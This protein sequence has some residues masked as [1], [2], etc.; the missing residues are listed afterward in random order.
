MNSD[1]KLENITFLFYCV[2]FL[3]MVFY[4]VT[5]IM[6]WTY[7]WNQISI[8]AACLFPLV[9]T[10]CCKFN[11]REFSKKIEKEILI[12]FLIIIIGLLN[13]YYSDDY[14]TTVKAMTLFLV[15]GIGA[16]IVTLLIVNNRRRQ[17]TLLTL[18]WV[19]L[20]L[21]CVHGT[22]EFFFN[23]SPLWFAYRPHLKAIHLGSFNPIPAGSLLILLIMGPLVLY[24][25]VNKWLQIVSIM[26]IIA[27]CIIILAIGK[28]GPVVGII[29][30]ILFVSIF[31][32]KQLWVTIL[33]AAMLLSAYGLG[34]WCG[35]FAPL[36]L[37][38][39]LK[40]SNSIAWRVENYFLAMHILPQRPFC[41]IGLHAPIHPYLTDYSERLNINSSNSHYRNY[42]K[43]LKTF[44]NSF[45]LILVEMGML[46][47]IAYLSLGGVI[48]KKLLNNC[49]KVKS[50]KKNAILFL[51]PL[52]GFLIHSLTFDSLAYPHLNWLFHSFLGLL[53]NL[54]KF[55]IVPRSENRQP[56]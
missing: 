36:Q 6:M 12:A 32:R 41:G 51:A 11:K 25:G 20:I 15:S 30:A 38:S 34:H 46:M 19:C 29:G 44:E 4:S 23:K 39:K 14:S 18:C 47:A 33:V 48:I 8:V 37:I 43:D 3:F 53:A 40:T 16:F 27:A 31:C 28:L 50:Q 45:L 7:P 10:I 2:S 21:L 5:A 22:I 26:S 56:T 17:I 9:L 52:F 13:I 55:N 1:F 42:I 24:H 49:W 35:G 54:D